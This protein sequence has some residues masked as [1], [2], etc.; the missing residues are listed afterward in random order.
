MPEGTRLWFDAN[1]LEAI[2]MSSNIFTAAELI[3]VIS[4][5][6]AVFCPILVWV[7][8]GTTPRLR[9]IP[10]AARQAPDSLLK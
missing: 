6:C 2:L 3:A 5:Y 8:S 10:I 1:F 4:L 7:I 9:G